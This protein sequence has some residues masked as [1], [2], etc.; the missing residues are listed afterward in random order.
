MHMTPMRM[1]LCGSQ[2]GFRPLRLP[3]EPLCIHYGPCGDRL[4]RIKQGLSNSLVSRIQLL[5]VCSAF[6]PGCYAGAILVKDFVL[7]AR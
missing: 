6:R 5:T 4:P 1:V 7:N 3:E 2:E